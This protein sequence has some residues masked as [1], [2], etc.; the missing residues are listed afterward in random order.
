MH[1][2]GVVRCIGVAGD[3]VSEERSIH[4]NTS[5]YDTS[6]TITNCK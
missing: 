2:S 3:R 6:I 4:T 5:Y 1:G